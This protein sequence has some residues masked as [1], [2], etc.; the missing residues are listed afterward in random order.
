MWKESVVINRISLFD[1]PWL[2]VVA[3][4]LM[5]WIYAPHQ[6]RYLYVAMFF[7][8]VCATIHQ[9]MLAA[10]MGIEVAIAATHPKLGRSFFLGNSIIFLGIMILQGAHIIPALEGLAP[11]LEFLLY[12]VG[13]ASIASYV[14]LAINTKES[15]NDLCR[16]GALAAGFLFLTAMPGQGGAV[17]FLSLIAFVAFAVLAYNTWKQDHGW[18]TVVI[19]GLLWILGVSFY[20]YEPISGMTVPP[21]QWGYPRTVEGFFHALSRG[22]YEKSNPTDLLS[23]DGLFRFVMQ[24]GMVSGSL[25]NSFSWVFLFVAL[26][27]FLFLF[28]MQQRERAWIIGLAAIYGCVGIL[29]TVLMNTTPDRQSADENKVFFTAS[30]A[31]IAIL[32]GYGLALVCA[33]M[34]THYRSFRVVGLMLG[35]VSIVPTV[36]VYFDSVNTTFYGG[37]DLLDYARIL[38]L[39]IIIAATFVLTALAARCFLK[40]KNN[41]ASLNDHFYFKA[42]TGGAIFLLVVSIFIAFARRTLADVSTAWPNLSFGEKLAAP[43]KVLLSGIP[44]I[45]HNIIHLLTA[46]PMIFAPNQYSLPVIGALIL[47]FAVVA[48]IAAVLVYR[49]RA[50]VAITLALFMLTPVYS[51]LAHWAKCEQRN[52]WFGYWFGHDM[53]TPP[54]ETPDLTPGANGK[55]ILSYDSKLREQAMKGPNGNLVYPE[56]DRDTIL[57]GGTDPGRFCPTYMIFCESFV[58]AK[59]KPADPAFDRRDVYLIT[60]NALADGTYLDYLRSQYFRSQQQ[61]PPFFSELLTYVAGL[62]HVGDNS[63]VRGTAK[64]AYD[65]LDVP[66]TKFGARVEARRRAEGVYP[67][68]EIYIPSPVDSQQSFKDYTDDVALRQRDGRLQ[69]GE[70]V[71]VDPVSGRVQVSGQVAVMMIN[72]LLC[73]VI[74]DHNPTN[75]FYIEESFP[76][77]WMYPYETPFGIIMK[78][79]RNPNVALPDDVFK[80]D[81]EFWSKYSERLIGN[82]ITYDTSVQQIADWVDKVYLRNNF[83]GFTGDR[84]FIRDDGGQK[85]FSKLRSSQAGIYAWRLR[86]LY[87]SPPPDPQYLP[88]RPKSDAEV[89]QLRKEC[90]FAFK[91]SFA[92][93]P[94]SPEAVIRYANFLFQFQRFDDALIVAKTCKKLDP[95]NSQITG[96][97]DQIEDIKKR[98]AEQTANNAQATTQ[99]QQVETEAREHPTNVQNLL[100]LG[101]AYIQMQRTNDAIALLDKVL[102]NPSPTYNE[103]AALAQLY[104]KLGYGYLDK[105]DAT[106]Q[107][108]VLIAPESIRPEAYYDLAALKAVMGK[109]REALDNLR[110][111][112][113]LNAKR[114]KANPTASDLA[115]TCRTDVRFDLLRSLPEFPKIVPPK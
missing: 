26:L 28:K 8:G 13:I 23:L 25:A 104:G 72:G 6:K 113:D 22:Q 50:P 62:A 41:T 11:T 60:Q 114:L 97:V 19:C 7:F 10:A 45:G 115:V 107:K 9:T 76:L 110:I 98:I 95:Y 80:R 93:C 4:C 61:D 27:P 20:F 66:F 53:F 64:L 36:T 59:D 49:N 57:F 70:I 34:A 43:F 78:I 1:V 32:I 81:H 46:L 3:A 84:R 69:P 54:F 109:T 67:P 21:M 44:E 87:P 14:W 35:V 56:M 82:W 63:L 79:N 96:L 5:R 38:L 88:Y 48:F 75:E 29:L 71:E 40:I 101:N 17:V 86:L 73:K 94:Y 15:F 24:L 100:M 2:M 68:K 111:A 65:L 89:E 42:S 103:L 106:L 99:L 83:T 90:D 51:G 18:F 58:P 102:A 105:L 55:T 108:L 52:H 31:V 91:Q 39:F 74:F 16:D 92:F 12:A 33:Y 85:A 77:E 37:V 112:M 30:H 47:V